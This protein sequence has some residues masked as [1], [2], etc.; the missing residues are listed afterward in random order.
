[1][2]TFEKVVKSKL[3]IELQRISSS[4][5]FSPRILNEDLDELRVTMEQ[6]GGKNLF[7]MFGDTPT[8]VPAWIWERIAHILQVLYEREG[9]EYVDI[10]SFNFMISTSTSTGSQPQLQSQVWIIDFG[11]AYYTD[12]PRGDA[13]KNWALAE[14]LEGSH[15]WNS[16]FY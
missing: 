15:I 7:D 11:D 9:I 16:D 13:P 4:Y 2:A 14:V 12:K 1:M 6:V 5:G 10:T 8:N 3:E